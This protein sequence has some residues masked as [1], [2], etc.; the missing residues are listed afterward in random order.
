MK[1]WLFVPLLALIAAAP[2][3]AGTSDIAL[4]HSKAFERAANARDAK[5]IAAMYA[6][7]AYVVWPGQGEEAHGSAAIQKLVDNFV[8]QL[9]KDARLT[10]EAQTAIPLGN[11]TIA[12]VGHWQQTFTDPD[13][14]A[15]RLDLRTTEIIKEE[16]GKWLYLVDHAS[17]GLPPPA[18]A[19]QPAAGK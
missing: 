4:A 2:A 10:I 1:R 13:G 8:A 7:D 17:I 3:L 16:K 9:P 12:V 15:Q 11:G 14:K 5:A 19:G 6:P 18:P